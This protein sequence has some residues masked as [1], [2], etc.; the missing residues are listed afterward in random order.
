MGIRIH[1]LE[2][3]DDQAGIDEID[4]GMAALGSNFADT[5]RPVVRMAEEVD[6]DDYKTLLRV[7][8]ID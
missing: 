5:V 8:G 6:L 1:V 2:R 3:M 4:A 7:A